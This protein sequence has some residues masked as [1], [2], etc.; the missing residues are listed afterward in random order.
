M[1][2]FSRR[3]LILSSVSAF[4]LSIAGAA[5]ALRTPDFFTDQ[6]DKEYISFKQARDRFDLLLDKQIAQSEQAFGTKYDT[7]DIRRRLWDSTQ[8]TLSEHYRPKEEDA[9]N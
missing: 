9:P 4:A 2:L 8:L 3:L 1:T 6:Q 7:K 5:A